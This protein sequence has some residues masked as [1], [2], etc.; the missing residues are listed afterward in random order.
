MKQP[1]SLWL[2]RI[3]KAWCEITGGHDNKVLGTFLN[4]GNELASSVSLEC[5]KCG[6]QTMWY[7]VPRRSKKS[8]DKDAAKFK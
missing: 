5:K 1:R 8:A 6:K 4:I 2:W 7:K 3:R